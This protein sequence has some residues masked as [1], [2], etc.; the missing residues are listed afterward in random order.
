MT[1]A[2][3]LVE[4]IETGGPR[5]LGTLA[6][7]V[8]KRKDVV[9]AALKSDPRFVHRGKTKASLWDVRKTSFDSREAAARWKCDPAVVEER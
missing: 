1:L 9:L 6:T 4:M 5:P 3:V 7:D 8:G 2:D